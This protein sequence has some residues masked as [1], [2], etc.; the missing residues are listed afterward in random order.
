MKNLSRG[1]AWGTRLPC[2]SG[3]SHNA[4]VRVI[5]DEVYGTGALRI[6]AISGDS[7]D[8][9]KTIGILLGNVLRETELNI[10]ENLEAITM[11][12]I[13]VVLRQC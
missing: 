13:S 10:R 8:D 4:H 12:M 5:D 2:D 11:K 3:G 7:L 1:Y 9:P 6:V